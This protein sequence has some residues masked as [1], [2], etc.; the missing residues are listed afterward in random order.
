MRLYLRFLDWATA[1][2]NVAV[3]VAGI[4]MTSIVAVEVFMRYVLSASFFFSEEASRV[5]FIWFCYLGA[6]LAFRYNAH[7]GLE[8]LR[9][10]L[11]PR[12]RFAVN[13][14]S[15]ACILAFLIGIIV[16][17]LQILPYQWGQTLNTLGISIFWAYLA[18]PVG[19]VLMMLQLSG[20]VLE[21]WTI[22][23]RSEIAGENDPAG[24]CDGS[25]GQ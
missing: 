6:S 19:A 22:P 10:G 2:T 20:K 11:S 9:T 17:S 25:P 3:I 1:A 13:L 23:E 12:G 15:G 8:L 21:A 4:A 7:I 14:A 18:V 16:G 5:L 24:H